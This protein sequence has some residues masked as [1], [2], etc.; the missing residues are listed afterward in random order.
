MFR[1]LF[2]RDMKKIMQKLSDLQLAV[3]LA[4]NSMNPET[5]Q[6]L[7]Y[8][9]MDIVNTIGGKEGSGMFANRMLTYFMD[10]AE[11]RLG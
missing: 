3:F 8:G 7:T 5:R 1:I 11:G 6:D 9:I 2:S 10:D 4:K